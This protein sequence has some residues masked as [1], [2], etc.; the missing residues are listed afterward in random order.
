[1]DFLS[2]TFAVFFIVSVF[3]YYAVPRK[4]RWGVLL[5]SSMIF[6]IWSAPYLVLYLLFSTVTTYAYG[7]WVKNH[8]EHGQGVLALV[9]SA[10]L[11]VLLLLKFYPLCEVRLGFPALHLLMPMGVSFYTLQVIAYCAGV[12]KG[13]TEAQNNFLK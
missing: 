10:N 9:I 12:Y 4:M 7:K 3:C 5:I 11:T 1:M 8:K 13:N 6:Y 2:L